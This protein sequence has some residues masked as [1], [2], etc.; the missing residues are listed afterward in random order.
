MMLLTVLDARIEVALSLTDGDEDGPPPLN[1]LDIDVSKSPAQVLVGIED[2]Y[3]RP[4]VDSAG[5][6]ILLAVVEEFVG[7]D[8]VLTLELEF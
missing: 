1:S 8:L 7:C 5:V 4:E 3:V 6:R 2:E